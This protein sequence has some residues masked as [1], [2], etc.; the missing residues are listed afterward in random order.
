[1]YCSTWPACLANS[2]AHELKQ[3]RQARAT[4]W[5]FFAP[6]EAR[7]AVCFGITHQH[8]RLTLRTLLEAGESGNGSGGGQ[9]K[10]ALRGVR[11]TVSGLARGPM[12]I[13]FDRAAYRRR[14][15]SGRRRV[16]AHPR[17][18]PECQRRLDFSRRRVPEHPCR[19]HFSRHRVA[20]IPAGVSRHPL[21]P[22][23]GLV[24]AWI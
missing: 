5:F 9:G 23:A 17:R 6:D 22:A 13:R 24:R 20:N 14:L 8:D 3:D 16:A 19:R 15:N 7:S 1:M 18:V 11:R 2:M 10:C 12:R 4:G 21:R